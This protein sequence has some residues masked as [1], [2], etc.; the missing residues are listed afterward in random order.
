MINDVANWRIIDESPDTPLDTVFPISKRAACLV[1]RNKASRL[2]RTN[3]LKVQGAIE[4]LKGLDYH[5]DKF[6]SLVRRLAE[7]DLTA[8]AQEL[9]IHL[10]HEVVAYLN[11][12][13]QFH[14]FLMSDFVRQ[15][16]ANATSTAPT[17][18]KFVILRMK[19]SAHRSIDKPKGESARVQEIQ[20]MNLSAIGGNIFEPK[21][22][23]PCNLL[24]AKTTADMLAFRKS[25]W[26]K[27]YFSQ[28]LIT[29][30]PKIVY[31]F[32]IEK[33]HPIIMREAYAIFEKVLK[34]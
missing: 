10:S 11:R 1:A 20:A 30:N 7:V 23:M 3:F 26:V 14:Y 2:L 18:E 15:N 24:E 27:C 21:P 12:L 4:M 33:E 16:C 22:G 28:Q 19:H 6:V 34:T 9:K 25:M 29:D 5:H 17:I 32:S 31:T 8:E 13:G